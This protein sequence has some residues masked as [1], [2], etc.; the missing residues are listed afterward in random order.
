M[1]INK[2]HVFGS[3]K[4]KKVK[5]QTLKA[6][7][8]NLTMKEAESIDDF[9]MKLN[10]LV[11]N[12]WTLGETVEENY[13]VKKFLRAMPSKFLQITSSIEQFG[14]LEQMSVE[15]II[16][17]LKGHEERLRGQSKNTGGKLLL[18]EEEWLKRKVLRDNF[19]S[20]ERSG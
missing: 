18:I 11:T 20:Q 14:D 3:C 4:V 2:N 1:N 13:I 5:V 15:E 7:F 17:S 8:E 16:G 9:S 6:E 12:I 19:C 10:V